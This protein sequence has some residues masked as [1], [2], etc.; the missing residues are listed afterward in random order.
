MC[1][2]V[3]YFLLFLFGFRFFDCS[4]IYNGK[5]AIQTKVMHIPYIK[6]LYH[7]IDHTYTLFNE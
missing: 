7:T 5:G 1:F 2:V 6:H 3:N 4:D